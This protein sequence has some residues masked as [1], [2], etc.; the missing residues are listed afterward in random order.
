MQQN[1]DKYQKEPDLEKKKHFETLLHKNDWMCVEQ[2]S[3]QHLVWEKVWRAVVMER[4]SLQRFCQETR[5]AE[6]EPL[7]GHI[8]DYDFQLGFFFFFCHFQVRMHK[9]SCISC[10]SRK[11]TFNLVPVCSAR[12]LNHNNNVENTHIVSTCLSV[13]TL[14]D[15]CRVLLSTQ[16]QNYTRQQ[17]ISVTPDRLPPG[18]PQETEH[19]NTWRDVYTAH[20]FSLSLMTITEIN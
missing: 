18:W 9:I 19:L 3:L 8:N 6:P 12:T 1:I 2:S 15:T 16:T 14:Y 17:P 20:T 5:A 11:N 10:L 7:S 13:Y 4:V